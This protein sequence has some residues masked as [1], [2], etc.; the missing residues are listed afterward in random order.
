MEAQ[1]YKFCRFGDNI[2]IYCKSY[3]EAFRQYQNV[4]AHL[5]KQERLLIN[6]EKSGVYKALNR[7]YLGYRFNEKNGK[8]IAKKEQK[9]YR[10]VYRDWYTTGIM[11]IDHNYHLI[12]EG[13]LTKH[14]FTILFEGD[15]GKKYIPVETAESIYVY[16]NVVFSGNFFEFVNKYGLNVN[17][18]DRYGEKVGSFVSQNNRRN[19]KTEIKQIKLYEDEKARLDLARR[20]EIASISNLRANLRYYERRKP[21]EMLQDTISY[22]TDLIHKLNDSKD[23]TGL[24]AL[25]ARARQKYYQCFNVIMTASGF[26]FKRRSKR[27][28]EDPLNAMI[29]FGNTLLYQRFANEINRTSLDIRIGVVHATNN[30]PESL[31]LDLADLFKPIIVDRTIFTLV[32]RKMLD[33]HDFVEVEN[34]G[35]YLSKNGKRLFLQEFERKIYQKIKY[36]GMERTYDFIMKNEVQKLKKFIEQGEVYKPYKYT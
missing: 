13:I 2:N 15:E 6:I 23:I 17:I 29:S 18:I 32:N 34:N 24:M 12:N 5:E 30:R 9:A 4:K 31:N 22:I 28:P 20:L 19:I 27:P 21:D 33:I 35:V 7:K 1:G 8:I 14:D 11:R 10:T 3:E 36:N 16:S 26:S 25:E